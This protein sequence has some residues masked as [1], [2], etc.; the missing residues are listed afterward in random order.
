MN[1][2]DW[3]SILINRC[4]ETSFIFF[5]PR[6]HMLDLSKE[7]TIWDLFHVNHCDILF[8]YMEE[9]NPSGLGLCLEIGY[10]KALNKLIILIDEKSI[11]DSIFR[12]SF[13]IARE[14]ATIIF[15]SFDDGVSYLKKLENGVFKP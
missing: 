5:N 2:N 9:S 6:N 3:Q 8:G 11:S 15:D 14:S 12:K 7:Y 1:N 10:A 4:K 13:S